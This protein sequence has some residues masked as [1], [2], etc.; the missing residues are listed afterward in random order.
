M[1]QRLA[2]LFLRASLVGALVSV[3][4]HLVLAALATSIVVAVVGLGKSPSTISAD[5]GLVVLT[6]TELSQLDTKPSESKGEASD[7]LA[8]PAPSADLGALTPDLTQPAGPIGGDLGAPAG[9]LGGA[10]DVSGVGEG[11]SLGGAGGGGARFFGVEAVGSRFAYIVDISGSMAGPKMAALQRELE[12]SIDELAERSSFHIILFSSDA[13]PLGGRAK[14]T[15]A[16]LKNKK[17]TI[18]L[19][20]GVNAG[21]ATNPSP[22]FEA[23]FELK[24]RPEAIYFMTDGLFNPEVASLV[25]QSNT[26]GGRIIPIHCIAFVSQDAEDIMRRIANESDGSYT[27][28]PGPGMLP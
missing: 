28:V 26:V 1:G 5:A 18:Q 21:G 27:F 23:V 22:A 6:E 11:G 24:P 7:S 3:A 19:I 13:K 15:E 8:E 14:W 4:V 20:E 25:R 9:E 17:A 10:G 12:K 2:R 16:S